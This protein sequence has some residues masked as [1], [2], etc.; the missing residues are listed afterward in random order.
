MLQAFLEKLETVKKQL[1]HQEIGFFHYFLDDGS[2]AMSEELGRSLIVHNKNLGL[3]VTLIEGYEA[4]F[5]G[6]K[7]ARPDLVVR[8]DCQEHDPLR[9]PEIVDHFSHTNLNALLLPVCYWVAGQPR[10]PMWRTLEQIVDFRR[11]LK[12]LK[13]E[14][15]LAIYNQVFPLGFQAYRTDFLEGLLPDFRR[16]TTIFR[17]LTG[18][19]PSWGF[20]LLAIM[21]AA[22]DDLDNIDFRF[23]GWMEPWLENRGADKIAAQ[24]E[25]AKTMIEVAKR[26]GCA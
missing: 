6:R 14:V 13:P 9:I 19:E 10:T 25:R 20:D 2:Q 15:I 4:V 23:G 11:A 3:T 8:I 21:L 16:S 17:E 22:R 26:L 1:I 5:G 18:K 7:G 24:Q 12:P